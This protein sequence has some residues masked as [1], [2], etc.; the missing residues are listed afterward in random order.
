MLL[1]VELS[2]FSISSSFFRIVPIR[3]N[4]S[5]CCAILSE[6][7]A[8]T[9]KFPTEWPQ[10]TTASLHSSRTSTTMTTNGELFDKFCSF[11]SLG[12]VQLSA[13]I[14]NRVKIDCHARMFMFQGT[15]EERWSVS[16]RSAYRQ[17]VSRSGV[18]ALD[19]A[20][21]RPLG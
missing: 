13:E 18:D 17:R 8:K 2:V 14:R 20:L 19:S 1:I 5:N 4:S 7:R 11:Q 10:R 6:N 21:I 15:G 3:E 16:G 9:G 12:C